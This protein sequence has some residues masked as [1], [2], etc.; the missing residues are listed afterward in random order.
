MWSVFLS[1]STSIEVSACTIVVSLTLLDLMTVSTPLRSPSPSAGIAV[2][3]PVAPHQRHHRH[4]RSNAQPVVQK[5][6]DRAE[7]IQ[8]QLGQSA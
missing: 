3:L 8:K 2:R 1:V 6:L 4:E 5:H 7:E